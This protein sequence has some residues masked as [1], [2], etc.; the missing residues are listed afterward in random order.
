MADQ[1]K[2]PAPDDDSNVRMDPE[3]V[4]G[5][6]DEDDDDFEDEED[7]DEEEDEDGSPAI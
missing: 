5:R 1:W 2:S 6:A 3:D 7:L 4:R